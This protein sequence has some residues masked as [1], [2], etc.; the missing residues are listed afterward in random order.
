MKSNNISKDELMGRNLLS[1]LVIAGITFSAISFFI[2]DEEIQEIFSYTEVTSVPP[3]ICENGLCNFKD[4]KETSNH[5]FVQLD[6]EISKTQQVLKNEQFTNLKLVKNLPVKES[7]VSGNKV[8][9]F[10]EKDSFIREGVQNSNDGSNQVLRI[11]GTGQTN[12]RA[13][14]SFNQDDIQN[15]ATDK[16]LESATLKLYIESN[17]HNWGDGQLLNIYSFETVWQEGNGV[18]TPVS[19]LLNPSDGV[20]WSCPT[21]SNK[22]GNQWNGGKFDQNPTDSIWISNQ[23]EGYWVKFDVTTDILDYLSSKE[24][25]GWIIMKSDENSEGQINIASRE[26]QSHIPELV[27]VFSDD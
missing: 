26:A 19:N 4:A 3:N 6:Q 2:L 12:N 7:E 11:M 27:L 24:N 1:L 25:F 17:N 15:V 8:T 20:T 18:S 5:M 16:N 23:V 22:C 21:D 13:L 9:L 14:I 10:A